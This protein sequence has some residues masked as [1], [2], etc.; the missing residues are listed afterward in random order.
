MAKHG[1]NSLPWAFIDI[2]STLQ[3]PGEEVS[4]ENRTAIEN[5]LRSGGR[6]S[7]ATGKHPQA[8]V[9][10]L[11]D[12]PAAGPH[13]VLNGGAIMGARRRAKLRRWGRRPESWRIF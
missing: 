5:Y 12:F 7:F 4:R 10:L 3:A 11:R 2:D 6:I 13:I 9:G 8:I 1:Q